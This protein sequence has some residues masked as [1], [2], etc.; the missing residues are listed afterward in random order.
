MQVRKYIR[1]DEAKK[2]QVIKAYAIHGNY[3]KAAEAVG[4]SRSSVFNEMKK[5]AVFKKAMEEAKACYV[6]DLEAILDKRIKDGTDKMSGILLM[7]KLKAEQPD[8]Y[9]ENVSHKVEGSVKITTH[10]PGPD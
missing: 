10:I 3:K 1:L 5:S 9:R 2:E 8:K 7:F 6:D 4:V